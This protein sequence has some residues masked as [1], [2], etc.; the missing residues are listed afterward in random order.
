M[1][2]VTIESVCVTVSIFVAVM[3][4][5]KLTLPGNV[6]PDKSTVP[7]NVLSPLTVCVPVVFV[8]SV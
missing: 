8:L 7:V 1:L 2:S 5:A 3:F 6:A 4:P